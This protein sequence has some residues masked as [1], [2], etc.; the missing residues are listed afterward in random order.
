MRREMAIAWAPT[1]VKDIL[2][3]R[4]YLARGKRDEPAASIEGLDPDGHIYRFEGEI[5]LEEIV[6]GLGRSTN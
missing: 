3:R 4:L 5:T 6:A 2:D 1:S